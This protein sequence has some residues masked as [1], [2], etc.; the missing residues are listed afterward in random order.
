MNHM[1][2]SILAKI[3]FLRLN[4]LLLEYF[5]VFNKPNSFTLV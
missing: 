4:E 5:D 1:V 3:K 2:E